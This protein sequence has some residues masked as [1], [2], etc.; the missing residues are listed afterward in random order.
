MI[1]IAE[2]LEILNNEY[3]PP[4]NHGHLTPS[5]ILISKDFKLYI[6]DLG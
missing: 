2:M 6:S 1:S 5:N 4:I 3:N